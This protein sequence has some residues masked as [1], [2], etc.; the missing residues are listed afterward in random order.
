MRKIIVVLLATALCAVARA[1]RPS[2][3]SIDTL[4]T[5][6][7]TERLLDNMYAVMGQSMRQG[8]QAALKGK[9]LSDEQQRSFD[10]V[11]TKLEQVMR[12]ELN[13][14]SLR[15]MY[16]QVYQETFTQN[17]VDGLIAFYKSPTGAAFVD[18]MPVVLQK[19]QAL[20][21]ARIAPLVKKINGAME[22]AVKEI[23]AAK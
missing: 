18:K 19:T 23:K 9:T 3:A 5:A 2:E 20:M 12:E 8:M 16:V 17:E 15:P 4:L 21:Q 1:E 6:A 14:A 13:W 10:A 11:P 7:K 22:E